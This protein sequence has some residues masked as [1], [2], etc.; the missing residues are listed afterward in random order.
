MADGGM[1]LQIDEALTEQLRVAA[2]ASGE[3]VEEFAR[4]ALEM[5]SEDRGG[6]EE[7]IAAFEEYDRTGVGRPADEVMA[8]FRA[9]IEAHFAKKV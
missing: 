7:D 1:T 4:R 6:W 8:E 3:T 2:A 9:S 5:W